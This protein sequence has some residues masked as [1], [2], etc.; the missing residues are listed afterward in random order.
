MAP[1]AKLQSLQDRAN[2]AKAAHD[3]AEVAFTELEIELPRVRELHQAANV[4]MGQ[5]KVAWK[6]AEDARARKL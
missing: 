4:N 1:S 5:T 2:A 6:K 3:A